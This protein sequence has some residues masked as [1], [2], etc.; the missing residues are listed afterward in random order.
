MPFLCFIAFTTAGAVMSGEPATVDLHLASAPNKGLAADR[1]HAVEVSDYRAS[2]FH[3][4]PGL[5]YLNDK[6]VSLELVGA[7]DFYLRHQNGIIKIHEH[8]KRLNLLF[9]QD[10]SWKIIKLGNDK[11]RIE[12]INYPGD[13]IT[14]RDDGYVV[15]SRNPPW[16]KSTF[17][18]R[19]R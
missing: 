4:V 7:K 5:T 1:G 12:S 2:K 9:E 6:A 19:S 8:P 14:V 3:L 15:K 13:F 10:A 17:L 16:E 11:V 18:M